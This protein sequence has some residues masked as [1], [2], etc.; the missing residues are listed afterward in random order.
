MKLTSPSPPVG[1]PSVADE[2]TVKVTNSLLFTFPAES[3]A[4]TLRVFIPV[5]AVNVV[6]TLQVY[7]VLV[8][9]LF[10]EYQ[11]DARFVSVLVTFNGIVDDEYVVFVGVFI[12]TWGAEASIV[13]YT[14]EL[15]SFP[16]ESFMNIVTV[17]NP[18]TH[19][20][21]ISFPHVIVVFIPPATSVHQQEST[22]VSE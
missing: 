12:M 16:A 14:L 8:A 18:P 17:F 2:D 7:V 10:N 20:P 11:Q 21:N 15:P 1:V 6:A 3:F 4:A 22:L 13:K 5:A 19:G 9:Q